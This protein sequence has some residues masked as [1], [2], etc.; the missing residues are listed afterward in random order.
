MLELT[1]NATRVL[2]HR[3]LAKRPDGTVSETPEQL[4]AR[5]GRA[6]ASAESA[7]AQVVVAQ[8]AAG[9]PARR[10]EAKL[11]VHGGAGIERGETG[12]EPAVGLAE[13]AGEADLEPANVEQLSVEIVRLAERITRAYTALE[14]PTQHDERQFAHMVRMRVTDKQ[15]IETLE[16]ISVIHKPLI[17]SSATVDHRQPTID[18]Q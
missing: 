4:F 1:D 13:P 8:E 14:S 5:V 18:I 2:A 3:Y 17:H 12:L 15:A 6:V 11:K 16:I 9:P 10:G 7:R